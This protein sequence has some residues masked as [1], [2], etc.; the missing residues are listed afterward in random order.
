MAGRAGILHLLPFSRSELAG[1]PNTPEDLFELLW[2][3]G[4]PPSTLADI[5]DAPVWPTP[6]LLTYV[7]RDVR[8]ILNVGDLGRFTTFLRCAPHTPRRS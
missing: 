3:G 4:Y 1:F 7:Q 8:Q 6:S 2:S 5:P